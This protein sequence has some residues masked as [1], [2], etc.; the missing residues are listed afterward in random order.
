MYTCTCIRLKL[1]F[2]K[3]LQTY[4]ST[5]GLVGSY[6]FK[7]KRKRRL[8]QRQERLNATVIFELCRIANFGLISIER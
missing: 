2:Y 3:A 1:S 5:P 4:V 7:K 6:L 8:A